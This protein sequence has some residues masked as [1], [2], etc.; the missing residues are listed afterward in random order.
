MRPDTSLHCVAADVATSNAES[1]P[2]DAELLAL[3]R[4]DPAERSRPPVQ[5]VGLQVHTGRLCAFDID[6]APLLESPLWPAS[7]L[8]RALTTIALEPEWVGARVVFV[9]ENNNPRKPIVIGVVHE[10]G[11]TLH[12]ASP[13]RTLAA[14]ADEKRIHLKA[15]REIVLECGGAS[16]TLTR[17]GK[18]I[19]KGAYVVSSSSG[20]NRIKGAVIDIN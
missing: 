20:S 19:I 12:R 13:D 18:V 6:D 3:L 10:P 4:R 17:A 2:A 1:V 14:A 11:S 9:L 16:I 15:A 8:Q 7:E 5:P